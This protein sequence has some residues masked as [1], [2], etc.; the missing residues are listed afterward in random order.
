MKNL[1]FYGLD[2]SNNRQLRMAIDTSG[3]IGLGIADPT[4]RLEIVG[5]LS[6]N[7]SIYHNGILFTPSETASTNIDQTT[8]IS[9]NNLKVHGDLSANDASF[10][11]IDVSAIFIQGRDLIGEDVPTA[12]DTLKELADALDNSANFATNVTN[13]LGTIQSD[14]STKQD[15]ISTNDLSLGDISGLYTQLNSKQDT[16]GDG[17][18]TIAKTSGLQTALDSKQAT[19][20]TNDLSLGDISGL[21]T[22]LNSKQNTIADGDLTIAKTSGLQTALDSKQAT[23][24]TNDLSLGD[25]SGLYT[26]LDSKQDTIADGDLT[27]AKTSGLQT[28]LDA[29]QATITTNDLSLGDISGLY[30]QLNSK[31]DTIADGDLTIAKTSGLQTTLDSK[32]ATITTNDLSL[33]DVSGLYTQLDSKQ[34]NIADGDLT[35]AK[36]SGLQTALDSKQATITTND[37]SL[38]DISGLYTQLDSKQD[39]IADGDL[40]IAKTSG[41]QTALDDKQD[42]IADGD[43]T[44]AKTSGLQTALNSKQDTITT[45]DLS[46][47]DI[48]G[49]YTQLANKQDTIADGGLTIAKTSGLQTALNSK[50]ATITTNDLSLGDISGLYTQLANKQDTIA[51]GGLTIAKTSGLQTALDSK[52]ATITES[53]DVSLNN[54]KVHGDLSANDASFNVL[55]A[56]Q[57]LINGEDL[58]GTIYTKINT[59]ID[60]AI[61]NLVDNAPIALD[62]LKELANALDNSANFASNVTVR[63]NA[64]E[65]DVAGKQDTISD[66]DLTIAKTAGLQTALNS[67]QDT[68]T[69]NDLSLGDISG[70]Y[71]QLANK[72]D[73]IADGGLTIAK[74][75]GLQTALNSKQDTITTNDLSLGD[76]SGLYTQLANKQDT[77]ADDDLTIAKTS[78]LQTALNSKQ[79]TITESVDVSLNNLKVHGDLSANDASFNVVDISSINTS[80]TSFMNSIIP[81]ANDTYSLGDI[82]NVWKDIYIGPGSLYIDGQKVIESDSSTIVVAADPNQNMKINTTGSGVLQLESAQGLEITSTGSGNITIGSTSTGTVR[83]TDN[84]ILSS[85]V[86]I[87]NETDTTVK[88]NDGLNVTGAYLQNGTNI[89]TIYASL[90]SPTLTGTPLAPTASSGTNTTQIATTAFVTTAIDDLIGGAPGALDTLNE[91]A[92][93][94]DN[95]GSFASNITTKVG[96]IETQLATKQDTLTAGT[97]ITITGSTISASGG[98]GSSLWSGSSDIYYTGGDVGIGTTSPAY[99]LDVFG[100]SRIKSDVTDLTVNVALDIS[101]SGYYGSGIRART[102]SS[103]SSIFSAQF[104]GNSGKGLTVLA[105]GAVGIGT[106]SGFSSHSLRIIGNPNT[107]SVQIYATGANYGILV[108]TAVSDTKYCAKFIGSTS[109]G[110]IVQSNGETIV[111]NDTRNLN[112]PALTVNYGHLRVTG[113]WGGWSSTGQISIVADKTIYSYTNIVSSDRR[114]KN[115]IVDVPDNLALTYVRNIPCCYYNYIDRP[116]EINTIGFIAQEVKDV[117]P[118]AV[119]IL[120]NFIP[121]IMQSV[122]GEWIEREDGKF[123]FSSHFFTDISFGTYKFRLKENISDTEYIEEEVSMNDDRSFTFEKTYYDVFC[124]GIE[125]DDFHALDKAKLFALNFSATQ[126]IDRIQQQHI[127]DISNAE[128]TI[129]SHEETIQQQQLEIENLKLINQ[130]MNNQLN[131]IKEHLGL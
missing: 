25:I 45:N 123:D 27:I 77:I 86:E 20:T 6:L 62:T 105:N 91:L 67:K 87:Q 97:N 1:N 114:I 63:L 89:N 112:N 88:I 81:N 58:S 15:S 101:G 51:D 110:L 100:P 85:G 39:N 90:S 79:P 21:Y 125:V 35:I 121:N 12:L 68:I 54:L 74:T 65:T 119:T 131:M 28:A 7:G 70:L 73:T 23:I 57:V 71:T 107:N 106:T 9:L 13:I 95:S 122:S 126:E 66:G 59:D 19:I 16:I 38:G 46:L 124:Y 93:A 83:I 22:Q 56:I 14:L 116:N 127:I 82:S 103:N 115:N 96:S 104:L 18:L 48:S 34:D 109:K 50:Q 129:Q 36:T 92:Q 84:I 30:T 64:I 41:L 111:E 117:F 44:I 102:A 72:Q 31:Q 40:T 42:N 78:G 53:V 55:E 10:N 8:D 130:D 61:S 33:G 76:I 75:S 128:A 60:N 24:T 29:K 43:L 26:Q 17:D 49:L 4:T 118:I 32:Q 52:Q 37:L 2:S 113:Y 69:T 47:G 120:T 94:L 5:D 11:V 108:Q 98:G 80:S 3:N 99:T